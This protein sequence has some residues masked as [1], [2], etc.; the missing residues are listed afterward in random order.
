[1]DRARRPCSGHGKRALDA[2]ERERERGGGG[3]CGRAGQCERG[4]RGIRGGRQRDENRVLRAE[5]HVDWF[6]AP[7]DG[8]H[9]RQR[10]GGGQCACGHARLLGRIVGQ[11]DHT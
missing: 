10:A 2:V 4:E 8:K 6:A 7:G 5:E 9:C 1:V 11:P 3:K